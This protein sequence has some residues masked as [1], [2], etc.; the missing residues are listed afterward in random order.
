MWGTHGCTMHKLEWLEVPVAYSQVLWRHRFG[1]RERL[2]QSCRRLPGQL[3]IACSAASG[4]LLEQVKCRMH[5]S[6]FF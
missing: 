2:E 5:S 4:H 6:S 3:H 1:W